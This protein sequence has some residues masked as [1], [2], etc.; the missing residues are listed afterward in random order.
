M[1]TKRPLGLHVTPT[2]AKSRSN[3]AKGSA[4]RVCYRKKVN[5]NRS[6]PNLL[7]MSREYLHELWNNNICNTDWC[8]KTT[9]DVLLLLLMSQ[10]DA[11]RAMVG[12]E[13]RIQQS[14][15]VWFTETLPDCL[16][17]LSPSSSARDFIDPQ[18]A[19]L[20]HTPV[21]DSAPRLKYWYR[22]R[23]TMSSLFLKHLA[24]FL[25]IKHIEH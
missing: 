16:R 24:C 11:K 1:E 3:Q 9:T 25:F 13:M 22:T 8:H 15:T 21:R 2:Y 5:I 20:E 6:G 12:G 10:D 4:W 23:N 14:G 17:Q 18:L 19:T 7:C